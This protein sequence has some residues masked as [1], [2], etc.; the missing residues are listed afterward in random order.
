MEQFK[1]YLDSIVNL[2]HREKMKS[3]LKWIQNQYQD[4]IPVIKWN[5]PM[6]VLG[7]TF[8]IGFSVSKQHIAISPEAYG[9]QEFS[10]RIQS[11]GYTHTSNLFRIL[12]NQE[13]DYELIS[14][15]IRFKMFDK[16]G[17]DSFWK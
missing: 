7:D 1:L 9:I 17:S 12:W 16:A 13:I 4:L 5:Q 14:E 11:S 15:M 6:F 8:I 10:E 3:L 2:E